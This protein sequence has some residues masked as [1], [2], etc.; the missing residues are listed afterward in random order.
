VSYRQRTAPKVLIDVSPDSTQSIQDGNSRALIREIEA[1]F[2]TL[3]T[4]LQKGH[5]GRKL[6]FLGVVYYAK[7]FVQT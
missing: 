6:L 4:A 2:T 3:K 5:G 1:S 7:M